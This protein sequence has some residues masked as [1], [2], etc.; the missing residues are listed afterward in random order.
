MKKIKVIK[1]A[2]MWE[3]YFYLQYRKNISELQKNN[4][5]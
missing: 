1:E 3:E 2:K 4:K 5:F